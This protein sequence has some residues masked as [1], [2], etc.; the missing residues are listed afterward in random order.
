MLAP[1]LRRLLASLRRTPLHP[2]WLLSEPNQAWVRQHACGRVLDVGCADR[3][4]EAALTP[5]CTYIGL[6]YPVTGRDLY[7]ANPTVYA[8]AAR[9]PFADASFDTVAMLEVLEHV[10]QPQAAL[11]EASRVLR[12]GGRLLLTMPF[13]YPMHDEPHDYQRYTTHGLKREIR[14]AGLHLERLDSTLGAIESA[15]LLAC[16]ALAGSA[17]AA[18]RQRSFGMVTL[19]LIALAIPSINCMAWLAARILPDWP[20][21]ASG[22]ALVAVKQ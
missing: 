21:L 17:Y 13:L 11:S 12:P 4:I 14:A 9:L 16:L 18:L 2:Q 3:W 6:D 20:A 1:T 22:H 19:P 7:A 5:D 10:E 8:D 15:G